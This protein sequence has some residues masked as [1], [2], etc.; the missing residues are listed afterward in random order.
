MRAPVRQGA[1]ALLSC[2][3]QQSPSRACGGKRACVCACGRACCVRG[4]VQGA[5]SREE[6]EQEER[7]ALA[8]EQQDLLACIDA[9]MFSASPAAAAA[10]SNGAGGGGGGVGGKGALLPAS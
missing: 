2:C 7:A 6:E 4:R 8:R 5:A 3:G 1:Q 9:L 10:G